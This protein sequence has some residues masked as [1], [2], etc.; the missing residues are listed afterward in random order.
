VK[1]RPFFGWGPETFAY[2]YWR[3]RPVAHNQTS[4]WNFLYN[5]AHNEWLSLAANTGLFGLGT[6]LLLLGWFTVLGFRLLQATGYRLQVTGENHDEL[7]ACRLSLVAILAAIL[8]VEIVNVF[9]FSTVTTQAYSYIFMAMAVVSTSEIRDHKSYISPS[10]VGFLNHKSYILYLILAVSALYLLSQI[11]ILFVADLSYNRARQLTN[12]GYY[13]EAI[14]PAQRAVDLAPEEPTFRS[15]LAETQGV[16]A[17][18][19]ASSDVEGPASSDV[20]GLTTT[21]A[22][23]D[24]SFMNFA[25]VGRQ[26][27]AN[28]SFLRTRARVTYALGAL[29]PTLSESGI[30]LMKRVTSVA[31]TDPK[32]F[33]TLGT[34]LEETGKT[35]EAKASYRR[36]LDLKPDYGEAKKALEGVFK[37]PDGSAP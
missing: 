15:E 36:A 30:D 22:L 2:T 7:V 1:Q 11:S 5:K 31:P 19:L 6:H 16:L 37:S 33:Y 29:D 17:V 28:V 34:M 21:I 4:E 20:E 32:P 24:A 35:E 18:S 8:G 27:P 3:D 14:G 10:Y 25:I 13:A 9:G 26:S 12:A 23:K